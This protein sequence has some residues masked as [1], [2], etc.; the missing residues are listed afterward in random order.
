MWRCGVDKNGPI[1]GDTHTHPTIET[2][3][4]LKVSDTDHFDPD[5]SV[6]IEDD[7]EQQ[8]VGNRQFSLEYMQRVVDFARPAIGFTIV[9]HASRRVTHPM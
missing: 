2:E 6:E 9:Q 4:S 1:S 5:Y 3:D 7:E 8:V